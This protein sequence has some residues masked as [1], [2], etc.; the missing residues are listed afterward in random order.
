VDS[1]A[2]KALLSVPLLKRLKVIDFMKSEVITISPVSSIE[3]T[4][5]LMKKKKIDA[6]PVLDGGKLVGIVASRDIALI[7]KKKWPDT[8]AR[9]VMKRELIL[10]YEYES[11]QVAL[12]RMTRNNI[13][14]LPIVDPKHPEKL[15]G[16]LT[17]KDIALSYDHYKEDLED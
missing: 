14:H 3:A 11:L 12:G 2:H 8:E 5:D 7:P 1:P 4:V 9:E 16:I 10:G 15:S 6:V 13:S 17:I